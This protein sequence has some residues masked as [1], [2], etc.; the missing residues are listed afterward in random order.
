VATSGTRGRV[1]LITG[2]GD[3]V[4]EDTDGVT[5]GVDAVVPS[6]SLAPPKMESSIPREFR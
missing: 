6:A 5:G 2:L 4:D 1:A 3:G